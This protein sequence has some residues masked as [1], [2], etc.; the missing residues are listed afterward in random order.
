MLVD[1]PVLIID[2]PILDDESIAK[3]YEFL[4]NLTFAFDAHYYNQLRRCSRTKT[5]SDSHTYL[6]DIQGDQRSLDDEIPF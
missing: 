2:A 1:N 5:Q 4:Q 6:N 3:V